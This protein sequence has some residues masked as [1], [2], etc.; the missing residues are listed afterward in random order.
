MKHAEAVARK[1]TAKVPST[2]TCLSIYT[3]ID[4][5]QTTSKPN[6]ISVDNRAGH[7]DAQEPGWLY[8]VVLSS[9]PWGCSRM[10]LM[11]TRLTVLPLMHF[12]GSRMHAYNRP[13][14]GVS[15]PRVFARDDTACCL[16]HRTF[17]H[18]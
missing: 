8:D 7:D 4:L 6:R 17:L 9:R 13:A 2:A 14:R 15:S 16:R 10:D 5:A 3:T 18:P 11:V 1:F 12:C